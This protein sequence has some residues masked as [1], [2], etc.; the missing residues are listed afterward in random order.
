MLVARDSP[1]NKCLGP[2]GARL[3]PA[4]PPDSFPG[5]LRKGDHFFVSLPSRSPNLY[6]WVAYFD[7]EIAA[8]ELMESDRLSIRA[9]HGDEAELDFPPLDWYVKYLKA[10]AAHDPGT[11]IACHW[12]DVRSPGTRRRELAV[13]KVVF[14][15]PGA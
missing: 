14:Y 9:R 7:D 13:H 8:E 5:R 6:G 10:V 2:K 12:R 3:V 11:P 15:D 1:D 4:F